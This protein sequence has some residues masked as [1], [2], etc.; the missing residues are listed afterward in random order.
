MWHDYS[1]EKPPKDGDYLVCGI[2][3][4][5][6]RFLHLE[7]YTEDLHSVDDWDFSDKEGVAGWYDYDSEWG[8]H[9]C[10]GI[11]HWMELP[12]LPPWK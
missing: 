12:E 7:S 6:Y 9:E 3:V 2:G 5:G 4:G 1:V 11:T 10:R 8:Y